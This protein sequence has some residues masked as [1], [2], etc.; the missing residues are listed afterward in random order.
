MYGIALGM[1]RGILYLH[2]GGGTKILQCDIKPSNVLLDSNFSA[3]IADFGLAKMIDKDRSH[4]S[5]STIQGTPRYTAT[6]TWLKNFGQV[7]E[8]SDVYNY[9]MLLLE[10][11]GRRNNYDAE[12]SGTSRVYFQEW[13][14][15]QIYKEEFSLL[16]KETGSN[17]SFGDIQEE[18]GKVMQ[19]MCLVGLWCIQHIPSKR[20]SMN[21]VI[22]MLGGHVEIEI[23]PYPFP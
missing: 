21:N 3:K 8:K 12:A 11:V 22:K 17:D 14:C 15:N 16:I 10:I 18:A 2:N 13:L 23:P 20:P 6:E 19:R 4:V 7:T 1:A 5:L 9:G